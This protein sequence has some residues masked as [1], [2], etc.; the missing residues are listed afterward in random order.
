MN[1]IAVDLSEIAWF[2]GSDPL[3][4]TQGRHYPEDQPCWGRDWKRPFTRS[5]K[6]TMALLRRRLWQHE[7]Q[8]LSCGLCLAE[9]YRPDEQAVL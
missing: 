9:P 6:V 7:R 1:E 3:H 4:E 8:G 5:F 2:I